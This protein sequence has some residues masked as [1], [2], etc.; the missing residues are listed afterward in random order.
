MNGPKGSESYYKSLYRNII[1]TIIIVSIFPSLLA[2]GMMAYQ[3][4]ASYKT[5]TLAYLQ[6]MVARHGQTIDTFLSERLANIRSLSS[7]ADRDKLTDDAYVAR[8]LKILREGY[9]EVFVDLG[10]VDSSGIQTAYSGPFRLERANYKDR[11]WFVKA[12]QSRFYISDVFLGLREQPHFI[13]SARVTIDQSPYI[14]RSTIDFEAFGKVV[15]NIKSGNSGAAFIIN[16]EGELQ[17]DSKGLD[18]ADRRKLEQIVS[19]Y[20]QDTSSHAGDVTIS[21]SGYIYTIT[22]LKNSQWVLIYMQK[23]GEAFKELYRTDLMLIALMVLGSIAIIIMALLLSRRTIKHIKKAD[24]EKEIMNSQVIEAGK[25]ASVG[26]LAAGIAHEINNPVAIMIEEAGWIE[27]LLEESEFKE[28][29]NLSEFRRAVTQIKTQGRRC[30]EITHK[31]LSFARKTDNAL[32]KTDVNLLIKD[33]I[34]VVEQRSRL[35]NIKVQTNLSPILPKVMVSPSET[36]QVLLNLIN[37][38]LD[39]ME[40]N[41]GTLSISTHRVGDTLSI[42]VTDT[43]DGIPEDIR[44][45]IFDPFFTTKQVGRGTGL[46]LSI[47]YG[48]I[49]KYGGEIKVS[50]TVGYGTAFHVSIPLKP[51]YPK[52]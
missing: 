31:I 43:G 39:A 22:P 7:S 51:E 14:I 1:L 17:T 19:S 20:F 32:K 26:E 52:Q 37:N 12:M 2:F 11:E 21:T 33:V 27:D 40:K 30:R 48:I 47:C 6:E 15:A 25:L 46:G 35:N 9:G 24:H 10:V 28:C 36:Q 50:S 16:R 45:K 41:G 23:E 38:A 34:S 18:E 5:R 49:K 42:D 4:N 3:F 44:N 13:V 29:E 8:Q